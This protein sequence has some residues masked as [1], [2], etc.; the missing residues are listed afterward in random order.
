MSMDRLQKQIR[1]L[2]N[3]TCVY[4]SAAQNQVPAHI[5]HAASSLCEAY[6]NY[7]CALLTELKELVP[8]VRFDFATFAVLGASG[9]QTLQNLLN[10]AADQGYYVILDAPEAKSANSAQIVARQL[11]DPD[12]LWRF[13]G[14]VLSCYIGSDGV[15][16]YVE[17]MKEQDKDLFL[18]LRTANKSALEL[19]DLMTGSRLVHLAAADMAKRLGEPFVGRSGYS[20]IGGVGAATS[21]DGLKTLRTKYPAMFLLIDG[22]DYSGANAKNCSAAFDKLGHGAIACVGATILE[23]WKLE[24]SD[25]LDYLTQAKQAAERVKKN[26]LRYVTVL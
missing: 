15:K 11:M 17:A 7:A 8:A 9:L 1:K 12:S 23:A 14:V 22:G 16:P 5:L 19:Q 21:A 18:L 20:R 26:L 3:P 10:F 25:G 6:E 24:N 2:K 4:F 13:D